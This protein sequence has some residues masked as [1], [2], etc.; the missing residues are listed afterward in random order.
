[1]IWKSFIEWWDKVGTLT[2]FDRQQG[3]ISDI[4]HA[5]DAEVTAKDAAIAT[6]KADKEK[7]EAACAEMLSFIENGVDD[8]YGTEA[9][10][11]GED[12]TWIDWGKRRKILANPNPGSRI[13]ARL[14][15]GE[16]LAE[17]ALAIK[18]DLESDRGELTCREWWGETPRVLLEAVKALAKWEAAK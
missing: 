9:A 3:M 15:A 12:A 17:S 13:Q 8:G 10:D 18:K 7:A 1:M 11:N 16:K 4:W 6:L 14:A 2:W 5:R